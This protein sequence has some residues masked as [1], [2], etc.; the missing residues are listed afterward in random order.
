[1]VLNTEVSQTRRRSHWRSA[2]SYRQTRRHSEKLVPFLCVS[3]KDSIDLQ[4]KL[5]VNAILYFQCVFPLFRPVQKA[6]CVMAR[7]LDTWTRKEAGLR[8]QRTLDQKTRVWR[9]LS[10]GQAKFSLLFCFFLF[11]WCPMPP[12]L[13]L[14]YHHNN[15]V[16]VAKWQTMRKMHKIYSQLARAMAKQICICYCICICIIGPCLFFF[17]E[18]HASAVARI[19]GQKWNPKNQTRSQCLPHAVAG[20][21][22]LVLASGSADQLLDIMG[23]LNG[24]SWHFMA[25][26]T[27][28]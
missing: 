5:T 22:S 17:C 9:H 3:T 28:S 14:A 23:I 16:K 2:N 10:L 11:G 4:N 27:F 20:A 13:W 25:F 12:T 26:I 7:Q 6:G 19:A 1:M 21:D 18:F 15:N 8:L 24:S